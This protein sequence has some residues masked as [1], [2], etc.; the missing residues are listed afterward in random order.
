ML[1]RLVEGE[2]RPLL[3]RGGECVKALWRAVHVLNDALTASD[4]VIMP[5]HVHLLLMVNY[6]KDPRFNPLV[7]IHWFMEE[8]ARMISTDGAAAP[9]LPTKPR[10]FRRFRPHCRGSITGVR[11]RSPRPLISFGRR[12]FGSISRFP[13]GN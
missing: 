13:L 3:S 8:S 2:K 6:D 7:F 12:A 4:F 5:D 10:R 11:G 9:L 1:S